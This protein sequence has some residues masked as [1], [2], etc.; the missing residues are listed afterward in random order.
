MDG[1]YDGLWQSLSGCGVNFC[2]S[3]LFPGDETP[4]EGYVGQLDSF[5]GYVFM[6]IRGIHRKPLLAFVVFQVPT[7]QNNQCIKVTRFRVTCPEVL[8]LYFREAYSATLQYRE[9]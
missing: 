9:R 2:S 5:G 7:T 4:E 3:L 1:R 6:K 8:H